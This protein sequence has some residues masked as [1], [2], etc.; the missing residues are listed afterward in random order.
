MMPGILT[1]LRYLRSS[2]RHVFV[3]LLPIAA[4][5]LMIGLFG[6]LDIILVAWILWPFMTSYIVCNIPRLL[7]REAAALAQRHVGAN[8][9]RCRIDTVHTSTPVEG[10]LAP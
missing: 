1:I 2:A 6:C 8:K 3:D 4:L 7:Y 9:C 5:M 10:I